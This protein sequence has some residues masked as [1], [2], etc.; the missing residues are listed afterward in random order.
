MSWGTEFS[1]NVLIRDTT[2]NSVKEAETLIEIT[3]IQID[4]L[5]TTLK[6]LASCN[7]KELT[8][9][10]AEPID[11][12]S[13]TVDELL[14]SI[15]EKTILIAYLNLYIGENGENKMS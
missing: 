10:D 14:L 2:I 11:F 7:I 4:K 8:P 15:R 12:A 13:N 3:E 9:D 5:I 1:A 6:M